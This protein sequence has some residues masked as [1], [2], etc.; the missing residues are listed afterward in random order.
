MFEDIQNLFLNQHGGYAKILQFE[1]LVIII[2]II[3]FFTIFFPNTYAFIIILLMF[4]IY[5][6]NSFVTIQNSSVNDFNH[7]TMV[8][9]Q[10]LQQKSNEHIRMKLDVIQNSNPS[11]LSQSE[12]QKMYDSN[13]L[14]SMYI[15]ANMIHF[16]DSILP[17]FE[18]NNYIYYSLLKGTNNILQN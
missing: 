7:I 14:N 11:V 12:I 5:F 18:Y 1:T 16:L 8:K 4:A 17:L 6:A 13:N 2:A 3:I 15:D 9:L 10:Q